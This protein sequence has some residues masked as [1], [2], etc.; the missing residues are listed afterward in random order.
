VQRLAFTGSRCRGVKLG[1]DNELLTVAE[2]GEVLLCA[3]AIGSPRLLQLSGVGDGDALRRLGID[4]VA[5]IA[6]VGANLQEHPLAMLGVRVDQRT[7]NLDARQPLRVAAFLAEWLFRRSGPATSPFSQAA[8]FFPGVEGSGRPE[9]EVL[10]APHYF[11]W[12]TSGPKPYPEPAVLGIASLCRPRARGRVSLRSSDPAAMPRIEHRMLDSAEDVAGLVRG[13]RIVRDIFAAG[14]FAQHVQGELMPGDAVQSDA[15]W[16]A[17]LRRSV[18]GGNHLVGTARMGSD[19][20]AVVSPTL[21]V[22]GL[23]GLRVVDAS[24]MPTLPSTHTNATVLAIAERAADLIRG[25]S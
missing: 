24:V 17:F 10:F 22:N 23:K 16:E 20:A 1:A 9:L 2:D 15:D 12:S 18:V 11:E 14:E 5:D 25:V 4:C 7:Y 13:C 8:A 3:G 6:G 19:D 21:R